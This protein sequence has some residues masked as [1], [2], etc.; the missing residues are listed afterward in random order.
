[1]S[2]IE[3]QSENLQTPRQ[4]L[5]DYEETL[6]DLKGYLVDLGLENDPL[7]LTGWFQTS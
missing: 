1:M 5:L 6:S 3:R 2:D 7:I 4:K